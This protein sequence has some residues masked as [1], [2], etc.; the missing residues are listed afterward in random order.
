MYSCSIYQ[1]TLISPVGCRNGSQRCGSGSEVLGLSCQR[2]RCQHRWPTSAERHAWL[3]WWCHGQ[4]SQPDWRNQKGH[5]QARRCRKSAETGPGQTHTVEI[6]LAKFTFYILKV[7]SQT[8][9]PLQ[10]QNC[11]I[12]DNRSTTE[13][14]DPDHISHLVGYWIGHIN[15]GCPPLTLYCTSVIT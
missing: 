13:N 3:C 4:I 7:K 10:H 11:V 5:C 8:S 12:Q 14:E 15:L 9:A 6:L 1:A 2:S